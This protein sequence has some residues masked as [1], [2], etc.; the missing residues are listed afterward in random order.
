MSNTVTNVAVLPNFQ[1]QC[2]TCY[3]CM[4]EKDVFR[5]KSLDIFGV[6]RDISLK[7][8]LEEPRNYWTPEDYEKYL[9]EHF[10]PYEEFPELLFL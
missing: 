4:V 6:C 10:K 2:P 8:D 5:V 7:F 1:N 3:R 9:I